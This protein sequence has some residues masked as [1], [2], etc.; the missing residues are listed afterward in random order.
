MKQQSTKPRV[1]T[2]LK[3]QLLYEWEITRAHPSLLEL[4]R[5]PELGLEGL[6]EKQSDRIE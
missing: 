1:F 6:M 5:L 4:H 3:N 2:S